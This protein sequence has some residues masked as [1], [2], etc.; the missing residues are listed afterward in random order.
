MNKNLA[1]SLIASLAVFGAFGAFYL[2][3]PPLKTGGIS[4]LQ[5]YAITSSYHDMYGTDDGLIV[6]NARNDQGI[7]SSTFKLN[8]TKYLFET[9]SA[10]LV[11][12]G[13][14]NLAITSSVKVAE[15]SKDAT[16]LTSLILFVKEKPNLIF[17][18]NGDAPVSIAKRVKDIKT[19]DLEFGNCIDIKSESTGPNERSFALGLKCDLSLGD[20]FRYLT[21]G[22]E[23]MSR[24]ATLTESYLAETGAQRVFS[25]QIGQK[26]QGTKLFKAG[27]SLSVFY[28][29]DDKTVDRGINFVYKP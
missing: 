13:S 23:L 16:M 17:S 8:D 28:K 3:T 11:V 7:L 19:S 5:S 14:N 1:V 18:L 26:D 15:S 2:A 4:P 22:D 12:Q 27:A 10:A 29:A 9:D 24:E 6:N 25:S 20:V 21:L